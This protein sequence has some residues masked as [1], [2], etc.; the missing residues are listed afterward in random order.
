MNTTYIQLLRTIESFAS[1]HLQVKK[2]GSD[3]PEQLP[4]FAT[5]DEA[6]PILFV[7]PSS[8]FSNEYTKTFNITVYSYDIIQQDRANI[9][10]ILS[11]THSILNDLVVWFNAESTPVDLIGTPTINPLNNALLDYCAGWSMN[12]TLEVD[13]STVCDIPFNEFPVVIEIKNDIIYSNYLTCETLAECPVIIDIQNALTGQSANTIIEVTYSELLNLK[14]TSALIKGQTYL[15]TDYMTTYIQPVTLANKT[16]GIIEPLYVIAT[17]V[18][19]LHNQCLSKLYPQDVVYYDIDNA[20]EG[21]TKGKIYRRFDTIKNNDIGTDWR[22]VK[23]DRSGV[24]NLLFENYSGFGITGNVIKT[25]DL[26]NTVVTYNLFMDNIIGDEFANNTINYSFRDNRIDNEFVNNAITGDFS[27]NKIGRGFGNNIIS[28]GFYFNEVVYDFNQNNISG[29][30]EYN[31]VDFG[32]YNNTISDTFDRNRIGSNFTNNTIMG[33]FSANDIDV[34]FDSNTITEYFGINKVMNG[35]YNNVINYDFNLND[36]GTSF[37]NNI[38]NIRFNDNIIG[39]AFS[40]NTL[41]G[42]SQNDMFTGNIIE[43]ACESNLIIGDVR[44]NKIGDRFAL[45]TITSDFSNNLIESGFDSNTINNSVSNDGFYDNNI[46]NAFNGNIITNSAFDRNDIGVSFGEN[47][48]TSDFNF[49][50]VD[51]SVTNNS[52]T[53]VTNST[54]GGQI[55]NIT[56]Q[57]YLERC[58]INRGNMTLNRPAPGFY[59]IGL[60]TF[61]WSPL[62]TP[63]TINDYTHI[64]NGTGNY[65]PTR[66]YSNGVKIM[67]EYQDS[68]EDTIIEQIL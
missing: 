43:V 50:K 37:E 58:N 5:K 44:H 15:I 40:L 14:N 27:F 21:F 41:S 51:F 18:N 36:I 29:I 30:F 20:T 3:F 57:V 62:N 49:N 13:N 28:N 10:T 39:W 17:D 1:E 52:F 8:T 64:S 65:F 45:N 46:G 11:D 42:S 23:Y 24:D 19:K 68:F 47:N 22:H 54:F 53:G 63:I 12:L 9:N 35:F 38:I 55:S 66:I 31:R 7:S 48:I 2:F 33:M 6:Y 16:S 34:Y 4:N 61:D 60:V 32:F 59:I 25:F 26:M 56:S 67:S